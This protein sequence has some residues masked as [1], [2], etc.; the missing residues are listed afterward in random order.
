ME[1]FLDKKEFDN[2]PVYNKDHL[3][4]KIKSHGDEVTDFYDNEIP[5]VVTNRTCLAIISLDFVLK[6]DEK[7]YLQSLFIYTKT[8][9]VRHIH[10][11]LNDFSYCIFKTMLTIH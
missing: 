11:N 6:K 3:K 5:K 1:V 8:K 9:V 10:D 2:E 7:Y 4:T